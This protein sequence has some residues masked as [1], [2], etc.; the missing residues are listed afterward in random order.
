MTTF[1]STI[2]TQAMML[3]PLTAADLMTHDP[4]SFDKY[5]PIQKASALLQLHALE[6]A[7]V[8]DELGR[9]AGVVTL[10]ACA[11]WDEFTLRSSPQSFVEQSHDWTSVTEIAHPA[12]ES[13][14]RTTPVHEVV[15]RLMQGPVRRLYVIND[16][17]ELVGVIS[18]PDVLL[19]LTKSGHPRSA[20]PACS[21]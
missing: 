8:V 6:A 9:L 10:A 15:N 20:E 5:T 17:N 2:A 19:H 21:C 12:V 11:A 13:T 18:M 16:R 1:A 14:R 4:L 3:R 7:P